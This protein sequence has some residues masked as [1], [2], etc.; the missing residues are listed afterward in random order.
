VD[1]HDMMR[2]A[3]TRVLT[4]AGYRVIEASTGE[5]AL[6]MAATLR[7]SLVLLDINLPGIDGLEV[8]KRLKADPD[9]ADVMVLQVSSA[10]GTTLDAAAGL[11]GGAD[12]YLVEPI[13]PL[14]LTATVRALLRLADRQRES[15]RLIRR[16]SRSERHLIEATEAAD[17]GLW[18]WDIAAGA[19]QWFGAHERLAGIQPGS[20]SGKIEFFSDILHP[21]DRERV[22]RKIHDT[23]AR[24][25]RH[26]ADHYRFVRPDGTVRSMAAVGRFFYDEA[27][28]AA[29][30]TGVVQ[31]V[32]ARMQA[33]DKLA[34]YRAIFAASTE[35]I[36]IID[37]DGRY[38]EQNAAHRAMLG[39]SDDELRGRTPAIHAGE[40]TFA[41][42]AR[43]LIET[44]RCRTEIRSR[45]KD[46][47]WLD[48]ALSAFA[49]YDD[50]GAVLCY[51]GIK[52]DITERKS[53][54][55][56]LR[57][58]R[59]AFFNLVQNAPFGVYVIDQDFRIHQVN[60][61]AQAVFS[62][63]RPL[64]G[65]DFAEA[66]RIIWPEPFATEAIERFR[67]TLATGES[68]IAPSLTLRRRDADRIESYEWQI[69]RVTLPDGQ[70]AAV[71][72]FYESTDIRRAERQG[73]ESE[74]RLRAILDHAPVAMFIKDRQGHHLFMNEECARVL[75]V[76]RD[77][78]AGK[79]EH[80]LFPAELADQFKKNDLPVWTSG[81]AQSIEEYLPQPDG[82]H[83]FLTQ[84]FLLRDLDGVPYALCGIAVDITERQRQADELRRWKDELEVR[85]HERTQEL[86][87]SQERLRALGSQL[88]VTEQRERQKLARDLHDY[89]A[90]ML[91]VGRMKMGMTK[92]QPGL[93]PETVAVLQDVD[94]IF[95]QALTYTRTLIAELTPPSFQEY[96]L[97]AALKWLAERMEKD[98]LWVDMQAS[99]EQV[100]LSEEQAVLV[101]QC[102]RELL[103]NVLKH[104]GVSRATVRCDTAQ[105]EVRVAVEDRGKGMSPEAMRR[106]EPGHLGLFAVRE[107][108]EAMGGRLEIDSGPG[109]GTTVTIVL[110]GGTK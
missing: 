3:R 57:R 66:L 46:G 38:I 88:A 104:A 36:A 47:G 39:Y 67:H 110:P 23:M 52:R 62:N 87:A 81:Q 83:T 45:R 90:Q 34:Q 4:Q 9:T 32:T 105:G 60:Q 84:K 109:R 103:F 48:V 7:P 13:E 50:D 15:L 35:G 28:H 26:Y 29:R 56:R 70:Q 85:V 43:E 99:C 91:A 71:C 11:D 22:W 20:F 41:G 59:D 95:Q 76:D 1:D 53:A 82:L 58:S 75:A 77:A 54:E 68:Y 74:A 78:A 31:D 98:G 27:G 30:M 96:G 61:G 55:E 69:H 10:R 24:G 44:G 73:R 49:V 100:P 8:C 14:E 16:L 72:Y 64:I 65:R 37:R 101:F 97:I 12:A 94:T 42:I 33:D 102:V 89:L 2:Y 21:D 40:D 6:L 93:A 107:R 63:V 18:D 25:E 80:E 92:K 19:L 5:E 108:M 86:Q 106:T 17:C 51:V 79:T